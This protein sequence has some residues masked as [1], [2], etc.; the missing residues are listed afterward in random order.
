[1]FTIFSDRKT[2][3]FA[4]LKYLPHAKNWWETYWEKSSIE[5]YGIYGTKPTWYVFLN[6]VVT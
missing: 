1:V 4:L 3:T 2:I 6:V 5:E